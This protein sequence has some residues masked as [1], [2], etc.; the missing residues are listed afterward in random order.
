MECPEASCL[1][2]KI[3]RSDEKDCFVLKTQGITQSI[4][5][6]LNKRQEAIDTKWR[7]L[8]VYITEM[9]PSLQHTMLTT[10]SMRYS[11]EEVSD[12]NCKECNDASFCEFSCLSEKGYFLLTFFLHYLSSHMLHVLTPSP[13]DTYSKT[14]MHVP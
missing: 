12:K 2:E 9:L 3:R 8:V 14:P 5:D 10:K 6:S 13:K 4:C 11:Q 7:F 1:E